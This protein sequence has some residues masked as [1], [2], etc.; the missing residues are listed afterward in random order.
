MGAAEAYPGPQALGQIREAELLRAAQVLGLREVRFLDYVDGHLD[1]ADPAEAVAKIAGHLRR[2]KPQVVVTFGPE[3]S[4]GHPDHIA[5]SQLTTAAC[6]QAA[7]AGG[8]AGAPH[9]VSKLYFMAESKEMLDV[10]EDVFGDIIMNVDGVARRP[11]PWLPWASTTRIDTSAYQDL[12]WKAVSC[13]QSQLSAYARLQQLTDLQHEILWGSRS[14]YRALSL[15]NG[16]RK[17]EDDLFEG[18]G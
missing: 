4:Y 13:H 9:S 1:Q 17:R 6:F 12:V 16:G 15:V 5:I 8:E 18:L 10:Y 3:G 11:A 7:A 2:V 14:F